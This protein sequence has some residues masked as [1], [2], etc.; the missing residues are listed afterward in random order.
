MITQPFIHGWDATLTRAELESAAGS[1]AHTLRD[2]TGSQARVGVYAKNSAATLASYLGIV[3]SGCQVVPLNTHLSPDELDFVVH[4]ADVRV[5]LCDEST[6]ER[7]E[8][9]QARSAT[10]VRVLLI[11]RDVDPMSHL[12]GGAAVDE[13]S[14]VRAPLMFTSGTSGRPKPVEMPPAQFPGGATVAEFRAWAAGLRFAGLGTHLVCGPL[15]HAG[16]LQAV[17]LSAAGTPVLVPRTFDAPALLHLIET[18]DVATSLMVPT[19]LVRFLAARRDGSTADCSS[20]KHVTLTG[21]VCPPDVKR[22]IIDWWG[23]VL[24]EGYGGTE[25]GGVCYISSAE[26]LERPTSVGRPADRFRVVVVDEAGQDL[27]VG[28]DGMLYFEDLSGRGIEY[29]DDPEASAKA[30]LRPGVFTL[31][32]IGH[33]DADG[34]VYLTDR[35]SEKIVSGGVNLYPAEVERVLLEHPEVADAV[36]IGVRDDEMGENVCAL[37]ELTPD[38]AADEQDLIDFCIVHLSRLKAPRVV[39]LVESLPRVTMGKVNRRRL[40]EQY[41][42]IALARRAGEVSH[43]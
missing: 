4:R 23:P 32:E 33:V 20:L 8:Q 6:L 43:V 29:L 36:V 21:A 9:L 42:P 41:E 1:V 31:G 35:D 7:A 26:W 34:Y 37:V 5:V 11:G 27:P 2:L 3:Y 38:A 10:Q 22:A 13:S 12:T 24:Y 40:R 18:H 30:H 39:L 16:P 25:S 15:Y 28:A 14:V 17:W 19:H